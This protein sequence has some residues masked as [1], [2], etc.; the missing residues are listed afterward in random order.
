Q[1]GR[2]V[3]SGSAF[4][5]RSL[6]SQHSGSSKPWFLW[7][8]FRLANHLNPLHYY[9]DSPYGQLHFRASSKRA[10]SRADFNGST[11]YRADRNRCKGAQ[12][13]Q[14]CLGLS[15]PGWWN[16]YLSDLS[17]WLALAASTY[18]VVRS[19]EN[20]HQ[21]NFRL[22]DSCNDYVRVDYSKV[23]KGHRHRPLCF[24]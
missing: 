17:I 19:L 22:I 6:Y 16:R 7:H 15:P 14:V 8:H 4:H 3:L 20:L 9:R 18:L 23:Q 5:G 2:A 11:R 24:K 1:P 10:S 12:G 13:T 21:A